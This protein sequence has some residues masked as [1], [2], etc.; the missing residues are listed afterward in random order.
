MIA[1]FVVASLD[2]SPITAEIRS[3]EPSAIVELFELDASSFGAGISRFHAGTNGLKQNVVWA[4]NTY[5]AFPVQAS[6][7]EWSGQGSLPRPRLTVANVTGAISLLVIQYDD[8]LGAKLTRR[9]TLV[10]YLD[11]VNFTGGINTNADPNA[12]FA[13]DVYYIDRKT[14]ETRDTVE[15]E[16]SAAFDVAGV[17][18]PRRQ[19]IQNVCQWV[20]RGAECSYTGGSYFD[21]NDAAVG[22]L[23]LDVCGKRLTS[24]KAR[25]GSYGELP[26]GSFPSAGLIK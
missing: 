14:L 17:Q 25:F 22:S 1:L 10:K 21:A 5:T 12:A 11:A 15:F 9:R 4:G 6:G 13:D 7:F 2:Y 23:G 24:C 19:I 8:L 20:Y 26:F 3:L 18:L 16:L